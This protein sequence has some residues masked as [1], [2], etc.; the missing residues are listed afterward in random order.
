MGLI[1][2]VILVLLARRGARELPD[3]YGPAGEPVLPP[4]RFSGRRT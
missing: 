4:S 1:G 3:A 2:M